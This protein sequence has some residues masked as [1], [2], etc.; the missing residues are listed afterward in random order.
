MLVSNAYTETIYPLPKDFKAST[1]PAT[2]T[3]TTAPAAS[4]G[5]PTCAVSNSSSSLNATSHDKCHSIS[6]SIGL[7]VGLGVPLAIALATI[8]WLATA[9]RRRKGHQPQVTSYE[10]NHDFGQAEKTTPSELDHGAMR[11]EA[12]T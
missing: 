4:S 5:V 8:A 11:Y 7:G 1:L 9:L 2:A 10:H 6:S 3:E 12:P